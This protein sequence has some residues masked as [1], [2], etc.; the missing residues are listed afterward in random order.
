VSLLGGNVGNTPNTSPSQWSLVA[1]AGTNGSSGSTGSSGSSG[2]SG[3]S[4]AAGS[5]GS[6]GTSGTSG[7]RG[8][9]GTS[10][11]SGAAGTSGSSGTSGTRGSSGT[12]GQSGAAGTSGSSGQSAATSLSNN[13][14]NYV[15]TATGNGSTPF[16][17]EVN[18][19]FD[20][21][22][23]SLNST[24][25]NI[26]SFTSSVLDGIAYS[27]I[28][29]SQQT[30][31]G[32]S[33][34]AAL[35]LV[36]RQGSST[37]GRHAY[38]GAEGVSGTT[39]RTQIKF[40]LR[41]ESAAYQWSTMTTQMTID[42]NGRVSIGTSLQEAAL[43]IALPGIDDQLVLGSA[44]TNRDIAMFMYSG[45]SKAEV[46]RYQS[47]VRLMIGSSAN[48]GYI[49][50]LPGGTQT[51]RVQSSGNVGINNTTPQYKLDVY[52][53]GIAASI[54]G[55]ISPGS[56]AGLHF[57]YLETGNTAY[58]KSALVFE[59]TDNNGQ[60]GNA[61]G[62]IHFL[63]NNVAAQSATALSSAVVTIDSDA[64]GTNGT[65][66]MGVGQS[67]PLAAL[68]VGTEALSTAGGHI[69]SWGQS[70]RW[71]R[72]RGATFAAGLVYKAWNHNA[73]THP[74]SEFGQTSW[75]RTHLTSFRASGITANCNVFT[76]SADNYYVEFYGYI[77]I[78]TARMY[79]FD[80][81]S[82]DSSDFFID[83]KRVGD[84]YGG[85][86]AS[87]A[88]NKGSIYLY[89]GYHRLYARF[90]EIDGGDSITLSYSTDGGSTYSIIPASILYHDPTDIVRSDGS[91]N[92]Y[93][94]ADVVAYATSDSRLKENIY[95][96][97]SPIEKIN[98]LNGVN[99]T[100]K[101]D[102][103]ADYKGTPDYGLIAQEV[104]KVL[105][106]A[107]ETRY[108]G[109]KAVRYEKVIPLLVE[110]VKELSTENQELKARLELIEA[111]I[112]D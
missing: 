103:Q 54:G 67:S 102:V 62:K 56:F 99:F 38:I 105:P 88:G 104:E 30:S 26:S 45:T 109:F 71:E 65:V 43:H 111:K 27:N 69:I 46:F 41:D 19:T 44:A 90:E 81:N 58:R 4:G 20:G 22:L 79:F 91:G 29:V 8:S 15:V 53:T 1:L 28:S 84:Y 108:N 101:K 24:V 59:R 92:V 52:N 78:D 31:S 55:T 93:Y 66:R 50:L 39:Y 57:G 94:F 75:Q 34:P 32:G 33:S 42:G 72:K 82:D 5:S 16:N 100:W 89:P 13:T 60:G 73:T 17:G 76:L 23:L 86:G 96:I 77:Y 10:G 7:T 36:G 35:E 51:I 63:L 80:I 40:K 98:K 3:Q 9:S 68:H 47:A 110:A 48:I 18:L 97:E 49:D 6:T 64:G 61:S 112:K 107:V 87:G 106:L 12:S 2:S 95:R 85:H 25:S 74:E 14:N 70:E 83:G 11:Q 21:S 37:H